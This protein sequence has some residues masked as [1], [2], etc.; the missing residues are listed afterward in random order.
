MLPFGLQLTSASTAQLV[1]TLLV[2]DCM[3]LANEVKVLCRKSTGQTQALTRLSVVRIKI[4][5]TPIRV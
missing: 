5:S 4:P 2:T 1:D 3:A